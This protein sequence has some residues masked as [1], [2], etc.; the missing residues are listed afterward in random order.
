MVTFKQFIT[1]AR[2]RDVMSRASVISKLKG[3]FSDAYAAWKDG[4]YLLRGTSNVNDNKSSFLVKTA[5]TLR[6]PL[7]G[8]EHYTRVLETNPLNA[9]WPSRVKSAICATDFSTAGDW[10][11]NREDGD[12]Y[13]VFPK[14][15]TKIAG[16]GTND[17]W[18]LRVNSKEG[19]LVSLKTIGAW[20][21][22]LCKFG[23]LNLENLSATRVVSDIEKYLEHT[24]PPKRVN[25]EITHFLKQYP[26]DEDFI[27][28]TAYVNTTSGANRMKTAL[29]DT[30]GIRSF[31][32]RGEF[33]FEGEYLCIHHKRMETYRYI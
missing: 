23:V 4:Q 21:S 24:I 8:G 10:A 33:W 19:G 5:T 12:T 25:E 31:P 2:D 32:A 6:N 26:T 14:N 18:G 1:E 30:T 3:D 15:G 17:I 9:E 16:I 7:P 28:A 11:S 13:Y 29:F 27:Q 20:I 22:E